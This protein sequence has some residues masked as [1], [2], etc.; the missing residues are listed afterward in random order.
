MNK[1]KRVTV[2]FS[3]LKCKYVTLAPC[4][5]RCWKDGDTS[6]LVPRRL[7]DILIHEKILGYCYAL[8]S[9]NQKHKL[10]T[11]TDNG[12]QMCKYKRFYTSLVFFFCFNRAHWA[13]HTKWI[14]RTENIKIIFGHSSHPIPVLVF[15]MKEYIDLLI[16]ENW[17]KRYEFS[18]FISAIYKLPSPKEKK[19]ALHQGGKFIGM[20]KTFFDNH[21]EIWFKDILLL[22]ISVTPATAYTFTNGT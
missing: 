15:I 1:M 5:N 2:I 7:S 16:E 13:R 3:W 8:T 14:H 4:R 9:S 6:I 18:T 22:S 12:L 21:Y 10:N 20:Y 11:I 17:R 19:L